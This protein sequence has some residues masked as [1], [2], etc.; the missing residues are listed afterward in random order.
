MGCLFFWGEYPDGSE[1][2]QPTLLE[3]D[4]NAR[5]IKITANE[6]SYGAISSTLFSLFLYHL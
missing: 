2:W 4:D 1:V 3:S 5:F 6:Q